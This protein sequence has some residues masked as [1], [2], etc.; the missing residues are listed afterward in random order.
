MIDPSSS[1]EESEEEHG[2]HHGHQQRGGRNE[3]P[4]YGHGL[5]VPNAAPR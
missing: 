5:E 2:H 4:G 3:T 1:E